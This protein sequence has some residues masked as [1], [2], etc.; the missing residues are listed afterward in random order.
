MS[1]NDEMEDLSPWVNGKY[2]D[3]WSIGH[4]LGGLG[5]GILLYKLGIDFYTSFVG[6][7]AG[8][9]LWEVFEKLYKDP[10]GWENRVV[11][12]FIGIAG[13]V[14]G[15]LVMEYLDSIEQTYIHS[16]S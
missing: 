9:I 15:Y 1:L 16:T 13:V 12:A 8:I 11:D 14:F 2:I 3:L 5:I 6:A 4:L 7:G 10:E